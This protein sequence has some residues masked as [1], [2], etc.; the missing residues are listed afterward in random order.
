MANETKNLTK[1][2]GTSVEALAGLKF[3]AEQNDTSLQSVADAAK[4]LSTSLADKPELFAKLGVTAKDS[5]GAMVQLPHI[6]P[7]IP[8]GAEK[9][10]LAVK[11]FGKAGLDMI[12][13]GR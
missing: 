9:S 1:K 11:L 4:K 3:A 10:A 8:D 2:T 7:A 6:F 13:I 12:Q 5:T